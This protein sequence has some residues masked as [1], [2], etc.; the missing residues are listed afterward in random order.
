MET[1]T[2]NGRKTF[3]LR[4]GWMQDDE[5]KYTKEELY[6]NKENQTFEVAKEIVVT[7]N[8]VNGSFVANWTKEWG[9]WAEFSLSPEVTALSSKATETLRR[10]AAAA[11]GSGKVEKG[12]KGPWAE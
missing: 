6:V 1:S 3:V 7:A 8:V 12:K 10:A 9:D 4:R 11:K 2:F 5:W